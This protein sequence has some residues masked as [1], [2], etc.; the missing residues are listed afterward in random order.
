MAALAPVEPGGAARCR[1]CGADLPKQG[2]LRR[3]S[4]CLTDSVTIGEQLAE[5]ERMT[6]KAIREARTS[7]SQGTEIAGRLLDSTAA[8]MQIF[9][10]TQ[11]FWLHIPVL[12]ALDGS[13]GMLIRLT[14]IFLAMLIGNA[15]STV[16]GIRWLSRRHD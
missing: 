9:V 7:V 3:C 6:M 10:Y 8:K 11:F 5:A 15:A 13:A 2:I 16:L 14:G 4:Y 1:F 12:V